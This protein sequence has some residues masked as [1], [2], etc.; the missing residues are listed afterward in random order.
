MSEDEVP[1]EQQT[2]PPDRTQGA[3]LP[4]GGPTGP[5][6]R[7]RPAQPPEPPKSDRELISQ[8][9][10]RPRMWLALIAIMVAATV[11]FSCV[12]IVLSGS[13]ITASVASVLTAVLSTVAGV[14]V[15]KKK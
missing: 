5:G 14:A 3:G 8:I 9:L 2:F 10:Y 4:D 1:R 12:V 6:H 13:W 7:G 11:C 15:R